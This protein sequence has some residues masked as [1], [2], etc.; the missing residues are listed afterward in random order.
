ML[1][2]GHAPIIRLAN[3]ARDPL[4]AGLSTGGHLQ[5]ARKNNTG[6]SVR[7]SICN[8]SQ[9]RACRTIQAQRFILQAIEYIDTSPCLTRHQPVRTLTR[10]KQGFRDVFPALLANMLGNR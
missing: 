4:L 2:L 9:A 8:D 10:E 1:F 7:R 5:G 3:P 6:S